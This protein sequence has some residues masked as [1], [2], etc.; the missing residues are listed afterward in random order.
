WS[1]YMREAPATKKLVVELARAGNA[2][3]RLEGSSLVADLPVDTEEWRKH[4]VPLLAEGL[5]LQRKARSGSVWSHEERLDQ[6]QPLV[7]FRIGDPGQ[8]VV[9]RFYSVKHARSYDRGLTEPIQKAVRRNWDAMLQKAL[10]GRGRIPGRLRALLPRLPVEE[11][12]RALLRDQDEA[13]GP[14]R[15]ELLEELAR[16]WNS[17]GHKPPAPTEQA[18]DGRYRKAWLDWYQKLVEGGHP[19]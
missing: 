2:W 16:E 3:L 5:E 13:S 17:A 1:G 14:K 15:L 12:V 8:S 9:L 4:G 18:G 7:R 11:R 19:F 6:E 10:L